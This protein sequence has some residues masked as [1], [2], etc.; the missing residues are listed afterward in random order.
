VSLPI[1]LYSWDTFAVSGST[2]RYKMNEKFSHKICNFHPEMKRF[3][4]SQNYE[5]ILCTTKTNSEHKL[6]LQFSVFV[7]KY[8]VNSNIVL[9]PKQT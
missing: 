1:L 3:I 8:V 2:F 5:K 9:A 4:W 6:Q 7:L